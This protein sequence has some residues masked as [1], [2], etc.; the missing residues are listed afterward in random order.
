MMR[1]RRISVSA[2]LAA[3]WLATAHA[4][5]VPRE[6]H[7]SAD[8]FAAPGMALA[9]GVLRGADDQ[10]TIV[11]IRIVADPAVFAEASAAGS[12]PFSGQRYQ[13]LVPTKI[14]GNIDLRLPRA[15]FAAFPRTIVVFRPKNALA[16]RHAPIADCARYDTI[17]SA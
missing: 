16:L 13:M 8:T 14:A 7:G 5:D 2:V 6:L 15:H 17:R 1:M 10:L 4:A 9:W 12:D 3:A 11:V